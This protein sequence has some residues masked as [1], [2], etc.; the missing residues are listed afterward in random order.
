MAY[1]REREQGKRGP[2]EVRHTAWCLVRRQ[3][4]LL[5]DALEIPVNTH[6][7]TQ[8]RMAHKD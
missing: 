6:T 7:H 2:K 8:T 4:V 5:T 3:G 1:E